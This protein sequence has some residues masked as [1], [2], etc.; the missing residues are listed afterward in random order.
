[1]L[2]HKY[3][4]QIRGKLSAMQSGGILATNLYNISVQKVSIP[5]EGRDGGIAALADGSCS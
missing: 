2:V 4:V 1:V 5:A 3:R